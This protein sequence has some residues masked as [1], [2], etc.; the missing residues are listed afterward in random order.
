MLS[1][2]KMLTKILQKLV[3]L[4]TSTTTTFASGT[5]GT[6]TAVQNANQKR[7]HL[8]KTGKIVRCY[9]GIGYANG[10]TAI[11]ANTTIFTIPTEYRPNSKKIF[12]AT[13]FRS[14]GKTVAPA[15]E[16]NTDGTIT[17]NSGNDLTMLVGSAEWE[18]N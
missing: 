5:L 12:P 6:N 3:A 15:F 16:F 11:P 2:K 18:T 7:C 8:V 14:I 9:V 1:I 13:G 4:Q 17:H 10:T